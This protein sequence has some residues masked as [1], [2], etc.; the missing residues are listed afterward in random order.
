M[1]RPSPLLSVAVVISALSPAAILAFQI[2]GGSTWPGILKHEVISS[3]IKGTSPLSMPIL[4]ASGTMFA[5]IK[6]SV[7][8]INSMP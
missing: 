3:G 7:E 2:W 8:L 6:P 4:H 5:Y 1:K